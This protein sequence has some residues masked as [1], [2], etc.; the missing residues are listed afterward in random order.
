MRTQ[1]IKKYVLFAS[2]GDFFFGKRENERNIFLFITHVGIKMLQFCADS[3]KLNKLFPLL[4]LCLLVAHILL[5]ARRKRKRSIHKR[6]V[7]ESALA[8]RESFPRM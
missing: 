7:F 3:I 2:I 6:A 8:R 1:N 5:A 4:A